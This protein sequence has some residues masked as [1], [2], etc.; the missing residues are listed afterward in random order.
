MSSTSPHAWPTN[1]PR[2][3]VCSHPPITSSLGQEA[4]EFAASV[5]LI[6]DHWQADGVHHLCAIRGDGRWQHFED[7]EIVARQNGKGVKGEIRVLAGLFLFG[8]QLLMWSAH[9]YKTASEA[10][11]RVRHWIDG[12]DELSKRVKRVSFSHAEEGIEL[13]DG[14]RL[15]FIARSK[16]SGRGFSGDVNIIDEAFAYTSQQQGALMPTMS[17]RPNPQIIYLSTPPLDGESGEVLYN[18]RARGEA[19]G[20]PSLCWRDWGAAG[21]LERLHEVDLDDEGL[22]RDTNPALGGRITLETVQRE[23]RAMDDIDF[24]RERLSIWPRRIT[25]DDDAAIDR[26]LWAELRDPKSQPGEYVSFA[27]DISPSRDWASIS[28]FSPRDDGRE[29]WELVDRR[30]GTD[31]VVARVVDL[32]A[33]HR[34]IV[35]A[36]DAAGPAGTLVEALDDAGITV[37][38]RPEEPHRGALIIPVVREVAMATGQAIDAVRQKLPAHIGQQELTEA[39][40]G[41]KL[42]TLG[43]GSAWGRRISTC[44]ISP[45]V[46]VTLARWAHLLHVQA[47]LEWDYDLLDSI[48]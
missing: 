48:V 45:L 5:G 30:A 33:E 40:R 18:L 42:R 31:W 7:A 35:W 28:V 23:R 32:N 29:H 3:R 37:P 15:R 1:A 27:V 17:A 25:A 24:A 6:A 26:R 34:P 41:A 44:D 38:E 21:G 16:G 12:S 10:F 8:E 19:G 4:V 11:R 39:V 36:L 22:W 43:D 2:P 47:V 13:T 14:A 46:A 9:E 20:D